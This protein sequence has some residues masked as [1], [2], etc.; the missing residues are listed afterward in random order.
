MIELIARLHVAYLAP[1]KSG[2]PRVADLINSDLT[3][4]GEP[5]PMAPGRR[6]ALAG[7]DV[8]H[9][10]SGAQEDVGEAGEQVKLADEATFAAALRRLRP[11]Q[12]ANAQID[13]IVDRS[14]NPPVV[15]IRPDAPPYTSAH[16]VTQL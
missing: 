2:P 13:V 15:Y 6:G 3:F 7:E 11:S 1:Q 8:R 12:A 5:E 4:V 9:L 10:H 16:E 14:K